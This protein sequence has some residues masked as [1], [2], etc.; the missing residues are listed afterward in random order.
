VTNAHDR[1]IGV[2]KLTDKELEKLLDDTEAAAKQD[3]DPEDAAQVSSAAHSKAK[4][5]AAKRETSA[6]RT[7]KKAA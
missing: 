7:R 2:E 6:S 5:A 3:H 4:S 1:Y